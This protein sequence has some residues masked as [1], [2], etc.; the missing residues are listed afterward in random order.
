MFTYRTV[1]STKNMYSHSWVFTN[2]HTHT[3]LLLD[4]PEVEILQCN[5]LEIRN[6]KINK[7]EIL[8]DYSRFV[9]V[10]NGNKFYK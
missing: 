8:K 4:F 10:Y 3:P 2:G 1:P 6:I 7:L 5:K 9:S